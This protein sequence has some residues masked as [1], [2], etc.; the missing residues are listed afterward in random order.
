MAAGF[1]VLATLETGSSYWL[2]LAGLIPLGAGM[3]LAGAPATTA[4]V[5]SLPHE[6]QG[7][8]SAV[9][10]VSR[11]LGGALGIAVLGSIFNSGYRSAVESQAA[12]LP[13]EAAE[14]VTGSLAG[15][16]QVGQG[17]GARG[18]ELVL[19]AQ[20]AFLQGLNHALL[21]GAAALVL[22][23]AFVAL[24]APGRAESEANAGQAAPAL[25]P[26]PTP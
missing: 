26:A 19:Q 18:Q 22:G 21:A 2:F 4:I 3:A 13:P 23:A 12:T 24:R 17:L 6:K 10:D 11:E 9:N 25:A 7:V 16:R 1:T 8:A 20:E 15:A 14:H 5:A